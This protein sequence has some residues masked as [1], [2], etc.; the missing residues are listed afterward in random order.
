MRR[1]EPDYANAAYWFRRVG[2]H[3]VYEPLRA[4]AVRLAVGAPAR[5][6]FLTGQRAWDPFAFVDLCEASCQ[7]T[8]PCHDLCRQVQ[9]A[10]WELLFAFCAEGAVANGAT[11]PP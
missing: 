4:E 9:R 6:A 11:P 8:A 3:P 5:A 1:R 10:E 7:E 2:T